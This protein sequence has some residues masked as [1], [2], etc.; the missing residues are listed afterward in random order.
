[1][2]KLVMLALLPLMLTGCEK[3]APEYQKAAELL[4][5]EQCDGIS[6]DFTHM[7]GF[8]AD[9]EGMFYTCISNSGSARIKIVYKDIPVKYFNFKEN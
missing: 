2:K 5:T 6:H 1:M 7:F 3:I 8:A 9:A 4:A